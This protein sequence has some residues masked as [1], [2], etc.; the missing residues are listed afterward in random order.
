MNGVSILHTPNPASATD[1]SRGNLNLN[2]I[3]SMLRRYYMADEV[4]WPS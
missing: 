4:G 1:S 3:E 2:A